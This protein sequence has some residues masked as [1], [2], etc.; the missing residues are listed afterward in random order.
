MWRIGPVMM[1]ALAYI[2]GTIAGNICL[3]TWETASWAVDPAVPGPTLP[4]AGR[5]LFDFVAADGIPFPFEA[6][7]RKV[8]AALRGLKKE[9]NS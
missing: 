9:Q 5:S 3:Q 2:P 8:E 4:P 6:L 7:V 1:I